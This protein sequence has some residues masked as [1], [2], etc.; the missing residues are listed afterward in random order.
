MAVNLI[1]TKCACD[2]HDIYIADFQVQIKKTKYIHKKNACFF[3][4]HDFIL[5]KKLLLQR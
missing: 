1:F 2:L 3:I 4:N 5:K